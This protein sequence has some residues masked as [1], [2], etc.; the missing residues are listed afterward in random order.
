MIK[1]MISYHIISL[2]VRAECVRCP[3]LMAQTKV[4]IVLGIIL[5]HN[6]NQL[7]NNIYNK[8]IIIPGLR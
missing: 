2:L 4:A 7:E 1:Y 6:P 3:W 8:A 5:P